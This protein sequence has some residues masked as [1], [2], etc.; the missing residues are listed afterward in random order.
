MKNILM[1]KTHSA[2]IGDLLRSS[3]SWRVLKNHFNN[4]KLNLLFLSDNPGYPSEKLISK[5]HLLDSFY[6]IDKRDMNKISGI[7]RVIK[8]S[9]E[10]IEK[11]NPDF[12]IDFEPYGLETTIVSMVARFKYKI[13]TLGINEIFPRGLLYSQYSSSVR[14]FRK[15]NNIKIL[16]YTDRDFV[17]LSALGIKRNNIPIEIEETEEAKKFRENLKSKLNTDKK[18]LGINIGCGTP[19]ALPRRPNLDLVVSVAKYLKEKYDYFILLFGA[20]Y[21][22]DINAEFIKR[23]GNSKDIYD[24]A[25]KTDILEVVGAINLTDLFI[26]SDSGPYHIAV[27]LKKPTVAIFNF[28]HPSAYHH[29]DWVRCIVAPN[30]DYK[31]VVIQACEEVIS[32]RE[33]SS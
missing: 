4:P 1:L 13:K 17:V 31:D 26:S 28:E 8:E 30:M 20:D 27:A 14:K 22:K 19:D 25:G 24:L 32:F 10:I 29:H 9:S 7:K 16:N 6:V 11:I 2:G 21:E 33:Y 5:H 23:F 12:V 15:E 3:A 18:I